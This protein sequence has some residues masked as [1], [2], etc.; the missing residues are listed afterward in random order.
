MR[1]IALRVGIIAAIA[2]GAWVFRDFLPS[3]AGSLAVGDCF[4]PPTGVSTV[5]DVQHHPCAEAHGGEVILV[6]DYEP[7]TD[8]YPSDDEFFAFMDT[9]CISAFNDYTG[10]EYTTADHL[11]YAAYTP[12]SDGW[13]EGD[14]KVIC[15]AVN[16]DGSQ[17][18]QSI[19]KAQ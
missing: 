11:D 16:V 10:L 9:R 15:Y 5:E 17:F 8:V 6:V 3:N 13:S 1:S 14:R 12:T 4:D 18:T 7:A 2:G 19:R